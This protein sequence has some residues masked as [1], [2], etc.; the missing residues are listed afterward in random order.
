MMYSKNSLL[1][2]FFLFQFQF[3]NRNEGICVF[4]IEFED[5][6]VTFDSQ[7]YLPGHLVRIGKIVIFQP[8]FPFRQTDFT[9][10]ALLS[11]DCG[12][13]LRMRPGG[14]AGG[15]NGLQ[16]IVDRLASDAWCRLRVGIGE[17]V[18]TP[19]DY[20]LGRF[21]SEAR[22]VMSRAWPRAADAVECWIQHGTELTM[23]RFNGDPPPSS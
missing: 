10:S 23:T 20:V 5:L 4:W 15:H 12:G 14:S 7:L 13:R 8:N 6:S 22:D 21:G 3:L 18:G 19:T 9:A 17:A 1:H 2:L 11:R 16:D